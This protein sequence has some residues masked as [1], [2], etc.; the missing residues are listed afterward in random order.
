[1]KNIDF[2]IFLIDSNDTDWIFEA[3]EELD[4]QMIVLFLHKMHFLMFFQSAGL[5]HSMGLKE[6]VQKLDL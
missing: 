1:M 4:T 3:K 5:P 2:V 6:I